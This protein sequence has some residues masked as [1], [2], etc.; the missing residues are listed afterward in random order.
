MTFAPVIPTPMED[1]QIQ[2]TDTDCSPA[3]RCVTATDAETRPTTPPE[4]SEK[5]ILPPPGFPQFQWPQADWILKGHPSLDPGLKFVTS[6]ST[7]IIKERAAELPPPPPPLSPITA[8][9]SQNSIMVQVG[10]PAD[11]TPTP[12]GL[13]QTRSTH[14][15]HPRLTQIREFQREKPAP[16]EDFL[17]KN[18]LRAPAMGAPRQPTEIKTGRGYHGDAWPER[19]RS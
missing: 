3:D 12:A 19:D 7:R 10:S 1:T 16:A 6:W 13:C 8:E 15:R 17:F 9:G 2:L 14:W 5:I 18:I 4:T 11:E